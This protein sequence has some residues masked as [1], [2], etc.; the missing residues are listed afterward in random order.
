M[1]KSV[2]IVYQSKHV[3]E[4]MF[5]LITEFLKNQNSLQ[6]LPGSR[7]LLRF[8]IGW[9]G[10]GGFW[11]RLTL[12]EVYFLEGVLIKGIKPRMAK[13]S[14]RPIPCGFPNIGISR[15]FGYFRALLWGFQ[16]I[17]TVVGCNPNFCVKF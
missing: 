9:C 3:T 1:W 13:A 15:I 10:K 5:F 12:K 8:P 7:N 2:L 17:S 4:S 11:L 16:Y 6:Q 14:E